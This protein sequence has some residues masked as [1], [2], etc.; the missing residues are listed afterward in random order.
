MFF[1]QSLLHSPR[2]LLSYD[3]TGDGWIRFQI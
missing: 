3:V 2:V 1:L